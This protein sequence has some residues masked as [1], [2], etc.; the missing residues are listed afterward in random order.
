MG[1]TATEGVGIECM[2]D[3]QTWKV[4]ALDA[5]ERN[6]QTLKRLIDVEERKWTWSE[7]T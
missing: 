7:R 2:R 1:S 6:E 3:F 5:S 4:Y